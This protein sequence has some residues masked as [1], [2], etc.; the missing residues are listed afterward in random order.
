MASW[1]TDENGKWH[2][3]KEKVGLINRSDKVLK[4]K[5]TDKEGKEYIEEVKPG[6]PYIYEGPDRAALYELWS[7]DKTG[8][9]TTIGEDFRTNTEFLEYYAKSRNAFGFASVQE[10]LDYLGYD[11]KQIK[12]DFNEKASVINKHELPNRIEEIKRL[13][14]G[15]DR[16]GGGNAKYGGFG[17][18]PDAAFSR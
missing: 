5:K 18:I 12:K 3:A 17:D 6:E 2:P 14:G 13:G 1:I 7:R 8:K 10:F 9:T 15:D 11:T 4:I 16:A